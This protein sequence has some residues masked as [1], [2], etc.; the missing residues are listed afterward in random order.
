[1]ITP[2]PLHQIDADLEA[3]EADLLAAGGEFTDEIEARH[4]AL[5]EMRADKVAGYAA[6]IR[7]LD[8]SADAVDAEVKRLTA[9]RNALRNSDR[10]L[11]DRLCEAM[12]RR[13][14]RQH[15]T[16]LGRVRVQR[17]GTRPVLI[18]VEPD[19]L[20]EPFRRVAVSA[21]KRALA[22]ALRAGDPEAE[23]VAAFGPAAVHLRID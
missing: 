6:V 8:L 10:R 23:R 21:D 19:A 16:P 17:S 1:M 5:L 14:E 13:G 22:D 2:L 11:K 20:P 18:L 7:R 12:C 15:E 9:H 4:D 3:L